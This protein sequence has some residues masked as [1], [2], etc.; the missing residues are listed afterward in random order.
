MK[1]LASVALCAAK[2][3]P[4]VASRSR[5]CAKAC[6]CDIKCYWGKHRKTGKHVKNGGPDMEEERKMKDEEK[7]KLEEEEE[8]I[9]IEKLKKIFQHVKTGRM[10]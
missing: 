1:L 5:S 9:V 8:Q 6:R 2:P 3:E 7:K 4:P 10:V